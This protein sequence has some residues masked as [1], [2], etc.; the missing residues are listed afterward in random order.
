RA[1]VTAWLRGGGESSGGPAAPA[2]TADLAIEKGRIVAIGR[3]DAPARRVLDVDGLI[4]APGFIDVHTHYDAQ[5]TWDPLLT[6][7]C[8]HG[9]TTAVL[10]NCGFALAPCRSDGRDA[11][12][13]ML[14]HVEGM[15]LASLR[16]GVPWGWESIPEYLS[17]LATGP[18]GPNVAALIGHSA[19]R[20]Y[21]LGDDAYARAA[22]GAEIEAMAALVRTAMDAG[23]L[24]FATSRSTG[25]VGAGGRPVPSRCATRAEVAA[26][27]RAMAASG[28]G[29]V[30]ITPDTF[31]LPAHHCAFL[32]A[33]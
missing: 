23:A 3:V 13:Q 1:R 6:P 31:P 15:P 33:L 27:T 2:V 20:A 17:L 21:V 14:E 29:V 19:L 18:L 11:L 9:V 25:H 5:V 12:L 22:T 28:R 7:S 4:V 32:Q 8:W 30:E 10:G 16:A 24:G 26:L